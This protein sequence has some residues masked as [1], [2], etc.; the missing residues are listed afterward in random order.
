MTKL[1]LLNTVISLNL[2][3][4]D[5]NSQHYEPSATERRQL[6][7]DLTRLLERRDRLVAES[8]RSGEQPFPPQ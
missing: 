3:Q 4:L 6:R 2:D 8:K 1:E 7:Q 5:P